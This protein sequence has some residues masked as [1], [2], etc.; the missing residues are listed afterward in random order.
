MAQLACPGNLALVR[1]LQELR[2]EVR[3]RRRAVAVALVGA[4]ALVVAA[5]GG[6]TNER[7]SV[8]SGTRI[9]SC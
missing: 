3:R 6:G 4:A 2:H 1:R 9:P 7:T 5:L 8:G